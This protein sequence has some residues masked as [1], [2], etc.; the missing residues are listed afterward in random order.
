MIATIG[1]E[2]LFHAQ[3]HWIKAEVIATW[4]A[5]NVTLVH[6]EGSTVASHGAHIHGWLT[7]GEA[8][9]YHSRA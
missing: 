7:Y 1:D 6:E 2:V 5:D 8:A 3:T 9:Q 4:A